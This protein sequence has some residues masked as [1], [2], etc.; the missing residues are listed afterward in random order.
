MGEAF[1]IGLFSA[2]QEKERCGGLS[3]LK[4]KA[5]GVFDES[6]GLVGEKGGEAG[7]KI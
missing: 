3:V 5:E 6:G 7:I 2:V 1:E 4:P